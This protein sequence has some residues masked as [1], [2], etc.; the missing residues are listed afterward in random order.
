MEAA[1]AAAADEQM[2]TPM[3]EN[4]LTPT[5]HASIRRKSSSSDSV[6][7][8]GTADGMTTAMQAAADVKPRRRLNRQRRPELVD[9]DTNVVGFRQLEPQHVDL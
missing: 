7:S 5:A 3:Q 8:S 6:G 2:F 1:A 9:E 4:A